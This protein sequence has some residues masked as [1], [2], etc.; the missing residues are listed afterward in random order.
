MNE[1][2]DD[3][4]LQLECTLFFERNPYALETVRGL[5]KK[6][7]RSELALEAVVERMSRLLILERIGEGERAI[8]TYHAPAVRQEL[9]LS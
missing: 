5:A 3:M 7:G 2:Q 9:D 6:L 1:T 8:Y 4:S